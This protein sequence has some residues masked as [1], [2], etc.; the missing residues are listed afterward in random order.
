MT[1]LSLEDLRKM[2]D[3]ELRK[4]AAEANDALRD[5]RFRVASLEHKNPNELRGLRRSVAQA[6]TLLRER[7]IATS[8][9]ALETSPSTTA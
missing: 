9:P 6:K 3:A 4:Y 7:E 2:S 8:M 5:M 1:L